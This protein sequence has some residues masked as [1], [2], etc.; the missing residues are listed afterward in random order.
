MV[1]S[2]NFTRQMLEKAGRDNDCAQVRKIIAALSNNKTSDHHKTTATWVM[3]VLHKLA[4][5][6]YDATLADIAKLPGLNFNQHSKSGQSLIHHACHRGY[7]KLLEEIL[8]NKATALDEQELERGLLQAASKNH[9][10]V[11]NLLLQCSQLNVNVTNESGKSALELACEHKSWESARLLLLDKRVLVTK[12]KNNC[13]YSRTL[14]LLWASCQWDLIDKLVKCREVD[15]NCVEDCSEQTILHKA[16]R[17]QNHDALVKAM[18]Y[19]V[20]VMRR[21]RDAMTPVHYAALHG[22]VE[23]LHCLLKR[24][25]TQIIETLATPHQVSAL[26]VGA[27]AGF[28]EVVDLLV[29]EHRAQVNVSSIDEQPMVLEVIAQGQQEVLHYFI[30]KGHVSLEALQS[31]VQEGLHDIG[32]DQEGAVG[33]AQ[34]VQYARCAWTTAISMGHSDIV[35]YLLDCG[36]ATGQVLDFNHYTWGNDRH[37]IVRAMMTFCQS[38][39][40]GKWVL[41]F[42]RHYLGELCGNIDRQRQWLHKVQRH[43]GVGRKRIRDEDCLVEGKLGQCLVDTIGKQ[44]KEVMPL[45]VPLQAVWEVSGIYHGILVQM[46]QSTMDKAHL[47]TQRWNVW[48]RNGAG[49]VVYPSLFKYH[50]W[51]ETQCQ[52]EDFIFSRFM[53]ADWLLSRIVGAN[54]TFCD[55]ERLI[56]SCSGNRQ[57]MHTSGRFDYFGG[58]VSEIWSFLG[59]DAQTVNALYEVSGGILVDVMH[60]SMRQWQNT[61]TS[62]AEKTGSTVL[63]EDK[64]KQLLY[65][66]SQRCFQYNHA[67]SVGKAAEDECWVWYKQARAIF[68]ACRLQLE[69]AQEKADLVD[70]EAERQK[71]AKFDPETD[72]TTCADESDEDDMSIMT[73]ASGCSIEGYSM[74]AANTRE[75]LRTGMRRPLDAGDARLE[76]SEKRSRIEISRVALRR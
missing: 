71:R 40:K 3:G 74:F 69:Q 52:T 61:L 21:D 49:D 43:V 37:A 5:E 42:G 60:E 36:L 64:I 62:Q 16:V 50:N 45:L 53:Q 17:Q 44:P 7:F 48:L 6:G 22:Q 75:G 59:P 23:A 39:T 8:K 19:E 38:T 55:K 1:R 13:L 67:Y 14:H 56:Y 73:D 11:V 30:E 70:E 33:T 12:V 34:P 2:K 51:L 18:D 26:Y 68:C 29:R 15:I 66:K 47:S 24:A 27:V 72:V 32:A 9:I 41:G 54:A 58:V 28:V 31:P 25:D 76:N 65:I 4:Q 20:D 46:I 57:A 35:H 63:I 10:Q